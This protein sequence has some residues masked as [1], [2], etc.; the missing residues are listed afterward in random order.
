MQKQPFSPHYGSGF[1]LT[2]TTT[3]TAFTGQLRPV[4]KNVVI[5][6]TGT[7]VFFVRIGTGAQTAVLNADFP[8]MPGKTVSLTKADGQDSISTI[9]A[10][11]GGT[12]FVICGEG[13]EF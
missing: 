3:S 2:A 1:A 8:V 9:A 5:V 10:A 13:F 12:G 11:A 7:A 6:N 4:A